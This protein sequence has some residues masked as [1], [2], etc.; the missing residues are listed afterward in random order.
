VARGGRVD[1]HRV[2]GPVRLRP[3][4]PLADLPHLRDG[5]ELLRPG[6]GGDEVLEGLR[7]GED[8]QRRAADLAAEP[9][10]HRVLGVDGDRVEVVV[11]PDLLVRAAEPKSSPMWCWSATSTTIVRRPRAA[12]AMPM[13]AD[14]VVLPTP[15][16]PVT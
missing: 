10:L 4:L 15:P 13:A 7:A 3:A 8:L 1:D 9:L 2:V 16:L 12:A 11:E 6:G 14:T 5:D